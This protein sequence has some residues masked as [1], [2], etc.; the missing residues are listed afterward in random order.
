MQSAFAKYYPSLLFILKNQAINP[1][2]IELGDLHGDEI[3][4][5]LITMEKLRLVY[6]AKQLVAISNDGKISFRNV[7]LE[8]ESDLIKFIES[9]TD[10]VI[11]E[12]DVTTF[13]ESNF[14]KPNPI[15][16]KT[17]NDTDFGVYF[18]KYVK[19]NGLIKYDE[20]TLEHVNKWC[21]D[22]PPTIKMWFHN[23]NKP[24][25]ISLDGHRRSNDLLSH[26]DKKQIIPISKQ[27]N[28]R[29]LQWPTG[30]QWGVIWTIIAG[31]IALWVYVI[32]PIMD[33][34]LHRP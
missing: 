21:I 7:L 15:S 22:N 16:E 19:G 10:D 34:I 2:E 28:I 24:L 23:L 9:K 29:R 1:N 31:V 11:S 32:K 6:L 8:L 12:V 3:Y 26:P 20:E 5:I 18:I 25:Y 14:I 27:P 17:K 4:S 13:M 33:D 30:T